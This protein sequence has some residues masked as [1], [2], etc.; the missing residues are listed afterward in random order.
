MD[1]RAAGVPVHAWGGCRTPIQA[2]L[3]AAEPLNGRE[4]D[5][6]IDIL[7]RRRALKRREAERALACELRIA[8]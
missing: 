5:D 2:A 6:Y 4:L 3:L 1:G 8:A 7:E